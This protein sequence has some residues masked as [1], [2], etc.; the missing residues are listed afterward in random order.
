MHEQA[1]AQQIILEAQKQGNVK[2]IT[3]EVGD[4][5][6]LPAGE[7]REI[8]VKMTDWKVEVRSKKAEVRCKCGFEGEPRIL[9]QLHDHS[10]YECSKCGA[11]MPEIVAG[12]QIVLKEVEIN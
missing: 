9:Q 12:D 3:V 5:A 7:M 8:L 11:T 1:I 4:L 10:V 2:A 6:H